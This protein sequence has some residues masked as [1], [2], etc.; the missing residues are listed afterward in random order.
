MQ[1]NKEFKMLRNLYALAT[2]LVFLGVVLP[3]ATLGPVSVN[4]VD[5]DD[6][7]LTFIAVAFLLIATLMVSKILGVIGSLI[8]LGIAVYEIQHVSG[9]VSVGIGLYL[10]LIGGIIGLI[11]TF[12][13]GRRRVVQ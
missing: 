8:A 2:V 12:V 13:T 1:A 4:G 6:G 10:V 9:R 7:L 5:T 3:W 11:G